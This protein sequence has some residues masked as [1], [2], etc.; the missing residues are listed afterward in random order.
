MDC[1]GPAPNARAGGQENENGVPT[2]YNR[3]AWAR[4]YLAKADLVDSSTRGVWALTEKGRS[5]GT[6]DEEELRELQR[7]VQQATRQSKPRQDAAAQPAQPDDSDPDEQ[8]SFEFLEYREAAKAALQRM[9]PAGFERFCQ[10]LLREARFESFF[11][12][13]AEREAARDGVMPIELVDADG[14][15]G[16]MEELQLGLSP[17]STYV[18]DSE[19]LDGFTD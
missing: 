5:A 18:L 16:L 6:L 4:F 13:E 8:A 2:L 9:S 11:S 1:R 10:R 12:R 14:I 19:F 7:R 17:V 15:V 3:V